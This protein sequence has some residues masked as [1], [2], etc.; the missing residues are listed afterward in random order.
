M[1]EFSALPTHVSSSLR[2]GEKRKGEKRSGEERRAYERRG[3]ERRE[4][5]VSNEE[6]VRLKEVCVLH[7]GLCSSV[8][9]SPFQYIVPVR[10]SCST[11][12]SCI[13]CRQCSPLLC[14]LHAV[15]PSQASLSRNTA[16]SSLNCLQYSPVKCLLPQ[17]SPLQYRPYSLTPSLLRLPTLCI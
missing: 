12:L 11:A 5:Y 8:Q 2:E 7:A 16:L 1:S 14:L 17:Y 4:S 9:Y 13:S 10:R 6:Q 15:Q 3:E